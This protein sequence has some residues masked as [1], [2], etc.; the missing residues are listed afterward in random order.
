MNFDPETFNFPIITFQEAFNVLNR[1]EVFVEK[2]VTE[3][4]D[5][6]RY[7]WTQL[8]A[9][10]LTVN[11]QLLS[12]QPQFQD[13]LR[14]NL[15]KFKQDKIDYCNEYQVAGPMEPGLAPREASDRLILFQVFSS[16]RLTFTLSFIYMQAC[17]L[18]FLESL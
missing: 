18:F 12:M 6:L 8:L 9:K 7:T 13:E 15:A 11:V 5:N 2:E 16:F 17:K 10:A 3:Q 1:Y 4:V 14:T